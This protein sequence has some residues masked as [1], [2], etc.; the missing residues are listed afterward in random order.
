MKPNGGWLCSPLKVI[1][2]IDPLKAYSIIF[3]TEHP[4]TVEQSKYFFEVL[5]SLV[6]YVFLLRQLYPG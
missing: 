4:L 6:V 5:E 2:S 3:L 1:L